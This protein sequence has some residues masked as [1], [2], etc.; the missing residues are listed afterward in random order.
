MITEAA[1]IFQLVQV[2]YD[3]L[4]GVLFNKFKCFGCNL[5]FCFPLIAGQET[6]KQALQEIVILPALRPEVGLP[7]LHIF[8]RK[9]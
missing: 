4:F 9:F 1:Q 6:A 8:T 2:V 7:V 3:V 5:Y